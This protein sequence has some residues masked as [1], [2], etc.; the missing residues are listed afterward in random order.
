MTKKRKG[1][2]DRDRLDWLEATA[3]THKILQENNRWLVASHFETIFIHK[4][5]EFSFNSLRKAIDAAIRK[6]KSCG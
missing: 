5:D 6:E 4:L 3:N 2:T 1:I